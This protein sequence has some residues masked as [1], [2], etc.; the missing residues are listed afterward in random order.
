MM[1]LMNDIWILVTSVFIH[2]PQGRSPSI[3]GMTC[4]AHSAVL[5]V[6]LSIFCG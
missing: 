3:L 4:V 2:N 6:V 5:V 1:E